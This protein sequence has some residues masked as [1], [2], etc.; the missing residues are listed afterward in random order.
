MGTE[1]KSKTNYFE[2]SLVVGF[3]IVIAIAA[4]VNLT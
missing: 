1:S 4:Y 3:I 2:I